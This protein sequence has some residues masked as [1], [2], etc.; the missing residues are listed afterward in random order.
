[1]TGD[2]GG[3]GKWGENPGVERIRTLNTQEL[4]LVPCPPPALSHVAAE[5]AH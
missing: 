3:T 1:M 5:R 2:P 4:A